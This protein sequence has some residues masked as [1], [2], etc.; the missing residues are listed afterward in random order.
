M[1]M[2]AW[3][4]APWK[5]TFIQF[6]LQHTHHAWG[7]WRIPEHAYG[8]VH[9]LQHRHELVGSNGQAIITGWVQRCRLWLAN[10]ACGWHGIRI[11]ADPDPSG[12]FHILVSMG[13]CA[14]YCRYLVYNSMSRLLLNTKDIIDV[15]CVIPM[16]LRWY[17]WDGPWG[18]MDGCQRLANAAMRLV[19]D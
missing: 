7:V 15:I 3:L 11:V 19:N 13:S 17:H 12:Q 9:D 6:G 14:T 5:R 2:C 16:Q 10:A 1:W 8:W 18:G 4:A